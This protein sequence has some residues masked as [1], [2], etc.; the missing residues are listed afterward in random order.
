MTDKNHSRPVIGV[1]VIVWRGRQIL[2]GERLVNGSSN[3]WQ[4]PGGHLESDESVIECAQREVLEETGLQVAALR[5]LG[6]TDKLFDMSG[7]KYIT[8]LVSCEHVSGEAVVLEPDKCASWQWFDCQ[9]LP[10]PLFLPITNFLSQ[11]SGCSHSLTTVSDL[12]AL[13]RA[14]QVLP[15]SPSGGHR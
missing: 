7:S 11:M 9:Q 10:S 4:F 15:E 1:G 6:Y 14:S 13:H 5:H 2:L 8:L 3:C 12:Y